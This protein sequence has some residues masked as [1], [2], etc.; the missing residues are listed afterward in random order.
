MC[1]RDSVKLLSP[2]P[3][4]PR[5]N[6]LA[7]RELAQACTQAFAPSAAYVHLSCPR[8]RF[9]VWSRVRQRALGNAVCS[10]TCCPRE[11]RHC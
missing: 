8:P 2:V 9:R 5:E 7:V 11:H 6:K 4:P 3:I 1:I 10:R